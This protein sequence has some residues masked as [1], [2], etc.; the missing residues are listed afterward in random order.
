M[1]CDRNKFRY[2]AHML[3]FYSFIALAVVTGI[4]FLGI[5]FIRIE[6]MLPLAQWNPVKILA[7]LGAV[8]L[9]AGC[10]IVISNRLKE[11]EDKSTSTYFDWVFIIMVYAV[12]I[13]GLL[14]ELTRLADAAVIAYSL[15]FI[16][17]VLVFYLIAYLPFSK[18]AHMIYR[19]VA[20]VYSSYSQREN[21]LTE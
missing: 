1:D 4:V 5:Y 7:N 16:H 2:L 20:L 13:S 8:A 18:F 15:Y 9:I 3:I 12:A 10:T 17:L 6:H 21:Q 11:E 19:T 14:T